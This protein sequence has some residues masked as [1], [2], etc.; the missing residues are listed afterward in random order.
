M[1]FEFCTFLFTSVGLRLALGLLVAALGWFAFFGVVQDFIAGD[2]LV[3]ADIRVIS[4]LQT[5]RTPGFNEVMLFFTYLGNWQVIA[6]GAVIFA[7]LTYLSR[8]WWWLGAFATSILGEQLLSQL[9][10][11][12]FHRDRPTLDNALLPAAG[13][14]FPSGHTLVAFAFYGFIAC[15]AV[16]HVRIRLVKTLIIAGAVLVI[17]GISFSRIYLGVHWPSDVIASLAL[18]PAWVATVLIVFKLTWPATPPDRLRPVSRWVVA[19]GVTVWMVAVVAFF[20]THPLVARA[21]VSRQPIALKANDFGTRLFDYVPRFTEDIT[22]A[23]IEPISVVIVGSEADLDRAMMDAGWVSAAPLSISSG[24]KLILA[25]LWNSPDPNAPGLPAFLAGLPNDKTFERATVQNSVRE[26]HHLHLWTTHLS[27]D[28]LAVWVGTT[29][30]DTS[31]NLYRGITYHKIDPDVDRERDALVRDLARS[32][33][34]SA[35]QAIDVTSP[36]RGQN[37][38][39][40]SFFTDGKAIQILLHCS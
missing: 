5:L 4:F 20:L 17:L 23:Q 31:A 33:C 3:R 7:L 38:V 2:P 13:G 19:A 36:M 26:R 10:K 1:L 29:H 25:D 22:G 28:G 11:L 14:S 39:H 32:N 34:V 24:L 8:Q 6:A 37:L 40:N 27:D 12:M 9:M 35:E 30:L 16:R 18:G 21:A 15:Y